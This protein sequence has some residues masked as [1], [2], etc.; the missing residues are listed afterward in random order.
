MREGQLLVHRLR[1]FDIA[2]TPVIPGMAFEL[3]HLP[4]PDLFH[5]HVAHAGTPEAVSLVGRIRKVPYIA[6]VHIDA[7]PTTWMGCFSVGT[8]G[9]C[10]PGY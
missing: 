4:R 8:R 5:V 2:V 9:T 6:H 7:G 3:L 1:A 10:W